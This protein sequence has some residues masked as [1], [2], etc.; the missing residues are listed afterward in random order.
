MLW[1]IPVVEIPECGFMEFREMSQSQKTSGELWSCEIR[2]V[3]EANLLFLQFPVTPWKQKVKET[4]AGILW[5]FLFLELIFAVFWA[6]VRLKQM[7]YKVYSHRFLQFL[8]SV[9]HWNVFIFELFHVW[10]LFTV[11]IFPKS[12]FKCSICIF[13]LMPARTWGF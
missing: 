1:A 3:W 8:E 5:H 12:C 2:G 10:C 4:D 6:V 13:I 9:L 11:A 7:N